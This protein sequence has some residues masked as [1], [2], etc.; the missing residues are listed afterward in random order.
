MM[1]L[2]PGA[3]TRDASPAFRA[4]YAGASMKE[5]LARA[6][7]ASRTLDALL[8][9]PAVAAVPPID[10]TRIAMTGHSRNGKQSLIA[11]AFDERISAIVGS[12]PGVPVTPVRFSTP[13][14]NGGFTSFAAWRHRDWWLPSLQD[15]L[16]REHE[17][18][19]D[20]HMI[21]ALIAPRHALLATARSDGESDNSFANEQS[22]LA[23][24]PV[25]ELLTG[26]SDALRI[27]WREGRH[28]GFVDPQHYF[29][30]FDY[31]AHLPSTRAS[32]AVEELP[33]VWN[34]TDWRDADC[35]GP[36]NALPAS[37]VCVGLCI[38]WEKFVYS[39][40]QQNL[41]ESTG[42]LGAAR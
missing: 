4:A 1:V 13:D 42:A 26:S 28:H 34:W 15:Y 24:R 8:D 22:V 9:G 39:S 19:A 16:G 17:L 31:S 25:W 7:V 11:A 10:R 14:F 33:H 3:D 35:I 30:W 32:F 38:G 12:S 23:N 41:F 21:L 20:G 5:I 29:D 40:A 27:Q 36:A 37:Y 2:Y 6:F 18:P